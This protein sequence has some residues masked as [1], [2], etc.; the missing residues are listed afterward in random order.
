[1]YSLSDECGIPSKSIYHKGWIDFNK[2]GV[3][4]IYEDP[5]APLEDRVQDLLSQMTLD[6]KPVRWPRFTV[7][8]V[9]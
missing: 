2:N 1:M 4:D 6:E 5:K 9:F 8:G 7:R 3:M